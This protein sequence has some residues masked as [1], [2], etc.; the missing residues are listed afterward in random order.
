LINIMTHTNEQLDK[1]F[2]ELPIELQDFIL[3]DEV[4][5]A[6]SIVE[7]EYNIPPS[8]SDDFVLKVLAM[9]LGLYFP[10]EFMRDIE[11][12]YNILEDISLKIYIDIYELV[13]EPAAYVLDPNDDENTTGNP[14]ESI[15]PAPIP[16]AEN[17]EPSIKKHILDEIEHPTPTPMKSVPLHQN[18]PISAYT[19]TSHESM[20]AAPLPMIQPHDLPTARVIPPHQPVTPI[21]GQISRQ[22]PW[23]TMPAVTP[24]QQPKTGP[25][26][27]LQQTEEHVHKMDMHPNLPEHEEDLMPLVIEQSKKAQQEGTHAPVVQ[28]TPHFKP[29]SAGETH[30]SVDPYREPTV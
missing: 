28:E 5:D 29:V 19:P 14:V 23:N 18:T 2:N 17:T 1:V 4:A 22:A 24:V 16:S 6:I 8:K 7:E 9:L 26:I 30:Y 15:G 20:H 13:L 11:R 27:L 10:E 25:S 3:S 21:S 12:E